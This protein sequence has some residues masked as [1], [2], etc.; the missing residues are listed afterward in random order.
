VELTA[1]ALSPGG[2]GKHPVLVYSVAVC[3]RARFRGVLLIGGGARLESSGS[4]RP[5]LVGPTADASSKTR[6]IPSLSHLAFES[7][8][9]G[10]RLRLGEVQAIPLDFEEPTRCPRDFSSKGALPF[11]GQVEQAIG[12]ASGAVRHEWAAPLGLWRGPRESQ[13]WPLIGTLPGVP[14]AELGVFRGLTGLQGDWSIPRR[15]YTGVDV[16]TLINAASV[17]LARPDPEEAGE[18]AWRGA[19][20]FAAAARLQDTDELSA[21]QQGLVVASLALGIGGS[22][23][24]T[25]ALDW[26]RGGRTP[27]GLRPTAESVD[28]APAYAAARHGEGRVA[29]AVAFLI[30]IAFV[31]RSIACIVARRRRS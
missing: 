29:S 11:F 2:A 22:I 27:H 7:I 31:A 26:V 12:A 6:H 19:Q 20:P 23:L 8:S 15:R 3:G 4:Q 17:E 25:L 1:A 28:T 21:W 24:A 14:L 18:L 9:S 5:S 30:G 13:V 16:G 10:R